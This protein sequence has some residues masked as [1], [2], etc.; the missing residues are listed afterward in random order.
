M[1]FLTL[2]FIFTAGLPVF[3]NHSAK[4]KAVLDAE[5]LKTA[6][7]IFVSP[8]NGDKVKQDFEV[9]FEV[10]GLTAEKSGQLHK[11]GGHHHILVN[12]GPVEKGKKI[13]KD[14][15]HLH[16][17]HGESKAKMHLKP[18]HYKLTLQFGDGEHYSYGPDLSDTIE[19]DVE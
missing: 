17:S 7:V 6:K 3:A 14:A 4:H 5:E 2:V 19:I 16:Y 18:G 11:G 12:S 13:P 1:R 10:K 8:K 15:V 9:E